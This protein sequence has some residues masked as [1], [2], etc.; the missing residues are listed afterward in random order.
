MKICIY[1][2]LRIEIFDFFLKNN[3]FNFESLKSVPSPPLKDP[4]N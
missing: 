1:N 4:I 2:A 3:F